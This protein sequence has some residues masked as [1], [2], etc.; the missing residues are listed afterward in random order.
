M[1]KN[2]GGRPKSITS[3]ELQ[4][5]KEAFMMGYNNTLACVHADVAERTFYQYCKANPEFSQKKELWKKRPLAKALNNVN[6]A[7]AEG[8]VNTSKW[9]LERKLKDEFSSRVEN[10]G[11][12]GGPQEVTV[13]QEEVRKFADELRGKESED[14]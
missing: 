8:D 11:K 9:L 7:L 12:D 3:D 6:Q 14:S 1:K 2:L 10:T 5:L 13:T 4:K